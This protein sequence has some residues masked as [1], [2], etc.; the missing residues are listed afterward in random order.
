[1]RWLGIVAIAGCGF[2][3]TTTSSEHPGDAAD[4]PVPITCGDLTCD[5]YAICD[6]SGPSCSCMAG[7]TGDGFTCADVD[8]CATANGGCPAACANEPGTFSCYAPAT[9]TEIDAKV[10]GGGDGDVTLYIDGDPAKPWAAFCANSKEY[11]TLP[12]GGTTNFAQYTKTPTS[13][14][15]SYTRIRLDPVTRLV[16]ISDQTYSSSTGTLMHG[17][18]LVQSMPY[19]VA[20]DCA[21]NNQN[22]GVASIDLSGT[23]FAVSD[24]FEIRGL[25]PRWHDR[26]VEHGPRRHAHRR[27]QLRLER[28]P[29]RSLQSVQHDR[30]A[31]ARRRVSTVASPIRARRR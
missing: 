21:G 20:M 8:E 22:T 27:R 9:C 31:A 28:A 16:D 1:M 2:A 17:M 7:F 5:P 4:A 12:A 19:G 10:P 11:L 3:P 6:A 24:P 13:V 25:A 15:T 30:R 18:T 29:A 26:E 23:P 14:R